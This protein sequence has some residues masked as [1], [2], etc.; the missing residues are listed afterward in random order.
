MGG[1]RGEDWGIILLLACFDGRRVEDTED[2]N[3]S[4]QTIWTL[5]Y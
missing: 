3:H 1:D 2:P 4:P 5:P